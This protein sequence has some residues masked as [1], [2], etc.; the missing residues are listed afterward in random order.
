[1]SIQY[2]IDL[3][4]AYLLAVIEAAAILIPLRGHVSV[5]GS[6]VAQHNTVAIPALISLGTI[7]VAAA[8][9]CSLAPT[10]RWYVPGDRPTAEQR[11]A[12]I[13]LA[14]RQSAILSGAWAIS[15]AI[16]MLLNLA[17]GAQ[18]LLPV[19]LGALL[20]GPA[21]AGT[22][23]LLA[24]RILRPIM[25]AATRD[26]EPRLAVPGVYARL[27]L[28]WFVGSAFPIG[29]IATLIVLRSHRWLIVGSAS[30]DVPILMVAL[31]AL[32]LGLPTMILTSRSISD[33][34]GEVVDAMAEVEH[35][36]IGTYVGAY[37]RS[38]IGRLQ[39]GF[40]RMVAGLV[41]R[42]RLRDLFGRHVG[43]DVAH[44]AITQ[45]ASLSGD[46]VEAAVLFID[47]VGSTHLAESR[48]P[49][50]VAGVLNDFFRIVVDAVDEHHGLVNKFA[51]DA[52]LAVFG[53]PLPT[54]EP[55][56]AALATARALGSQ[57]RRLPVVDFGIGVSAGR[58]F[59]GNIGAEN[60]YEYTV[61]GDAV[62]EAARLADLAKTADRRILCA[63]RAIEWAGEAERAH[64]AEIYSTVLRGRSEPTH[65]CAPAPAN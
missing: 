40:N 22:G 51:G 46:V 42:E 36:R 37:E 57:L 2:G 15:G 5:V 59:A 11:D 64:W 39:T 10:L 32:I 48:S 23:M 3:A 45:G 31:A 29:V 47:L 24:Q 55:A 50:A 28:M 60:R 58:V 19:A 56:S 4:S 6:T 8:G 27:V 49:Q 26:G 61:I 35:G 62:N 21:A 17:G 41:E 33:P 65:V 9:V 54:S 43:T 25:V 7:G 34:I 38:Q 16:F 63:A 53:V 13:R 12:A 20:G 44:R 18:L 1:M 52:A 14:G 30:L